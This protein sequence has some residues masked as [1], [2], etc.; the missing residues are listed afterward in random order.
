MGQKSYKNFEFIASEAYLHMTCSGVPG[1]PMG[2][3]VVPSPWSWEPMSLDESKG[4]LNESYKGPE[5][6]DKFISFGTKS[7][8]LGIKVLNVQMEP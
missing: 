7:F 3:V 6:E 5:N 4:I 1:V 2:A 8:T